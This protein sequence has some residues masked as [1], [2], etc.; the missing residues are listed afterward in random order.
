MADDARWD[1]N[2]YVG[3]RSIATI[4][5]REAG[6]DELTR[7]LTTLRLGLDL[8]AVMVRSDERAAD[9]RRLLHLLRETSERIAALIARLVAQPAPA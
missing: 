7:A 8:L 2:W 5:G 3:E 9:A 4:T 1:V 6:G